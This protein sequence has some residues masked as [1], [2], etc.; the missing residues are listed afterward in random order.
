[1]TAATTPASPTIYALSSGQGRA[2]VAVVR[3]SG[4]RAE[5]AV[6]TLAGKLPP[7]RMAAL[8]K[9]RAASGEVIDQAL[10]LWFPG[11]RSETGEDMAEFHLHGAPVLVEMLFRELSALGLRLAEPGEFIRRAFAH[12]KVDLVVAEG[13]ADLLA[14]SGEAQRRLAMRQFLGQV[15]AVYEQWR[16][17]IVAILAL[18]EAAIDFVEEDDVAAKAKSA[19]LPRLIRLR[20]DLASALARSDQNTAIRAG[21]KLVIAGPPNAGKSS[22]LNALLGRE[23]AITSPI[24]GTTRDVI[25]AHMMFEGLPL[26]LADTAGLRH[27]T[28]DDIEQQGMARARSA[29]H[30]ADILLWV[31]APDAEAKVGPPRE[32]DLVVANKSD[33][34]GLQSIQVRNDLAIAVSAKTGAGMNHLREALKKMIH[35]KLSGLEDAVV[36]RERH[37]VAVAEA[38]RLLEA[39]IA[40]PDR[41]DEVAAEDLRAAAR[42]LSSITGH[43]DVEDLLTKIFSEFCIGK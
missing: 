4:P 38:L 6:V 14:A 23:A 37:R 2:G 26:T 29:I 39:C 34:A 9:L 7:A 36:V 21:L 32:P 35:V 17:D 1:M 16:S 30:D 33:L 19:A 42:A 18:H 41:P 25:E 20:N 24:A 22:L 8:R 3:V 12:G 5:M 27:D 15:S 31:S 28:A 11:P 40:Q 10:V 13:L 43:V